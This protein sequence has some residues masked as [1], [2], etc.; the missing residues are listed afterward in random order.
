MIPYDAYVLR[1]EELPCF[2]RHSIYRKTYFSPKGTQV[3]QRVPLWLSRLFKTKSPLFSKEVEAT[4]H[5]FETVDKPTGDPSVSVLEEVIRRYTDVQTIPVENLDTFGRIETEYIG[6]RFMP[7]IVRQKQGILDRFFEY[8]IMLLHG[9]YA[10]DAGH[11]IAQFQIDMA[12]NRDK[13]IQELMQKGITLKKPT[14]EE[15]ANEF[16][17]RYSARIGSSES[18]KEKF[19]ELLTSGGDAII[20][21]DLGSCNVAWYKGRIA[22][23]DFE[24]L[25]FGNP[26]KD[27]AL[28]NLIAGLDP[29]SEILFNEDT[30]ISAYRKTIDEAISLN[31]RLSYLKQGDLKRTYQKEKLRE[32]IL[33]VGSYI[34]KYDSSCKRA[35]PDQQ[36]LKNAAVM[37][38]ESFKIVKQLRKQDQRFNELGYLLAESL[39]NAKYSFLQRIGVAFK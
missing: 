2:A 12:A 32:A 38:E 9:I 13:I 22:L 17:R 3:K 19:L 11:A 15:E 25:Q 5:T 34:A 36:M 18:L 10:K 26:L 23:N 28:C 37:A 21:G 31:P 27:V 6:P 39:E 24:R 16:D 33:H 1:I 4:Q 7:E 14:K 29:R 30:I 8:S 35:E 20:H